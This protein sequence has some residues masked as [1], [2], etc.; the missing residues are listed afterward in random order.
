MGLGF[1]PQTGHLVIGKKVLVNLGM[2]S[3][4]KAVAFFYALNRVGS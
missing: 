1:E 4:V 3:F 2:S